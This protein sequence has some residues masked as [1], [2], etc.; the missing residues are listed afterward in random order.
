MYVHPQKF[1]LLAYTKITVSYCVSYYNASAFSAM[2]AMY[3]SAIFTVPIIPITLDYSVMPKPKP[4]ASSKAQQKAC[5]L[6]CD[7]LE[8]QHEE[9]VCKGGCNST[10]HH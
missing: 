2:A 10:V 8:E 6:C 5:D 7:Q 9:L 3:L 4:K 1:R